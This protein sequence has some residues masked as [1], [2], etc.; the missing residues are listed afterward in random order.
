MLNSQLHAPTALPPIEP[1]FAATKKEPM[2]V[3]G[4]VEPLAK[5]EIL[6]FL[7]EVEPQIQPKVKSLY[8]QNYPGSF[9]ISAAVN[10][11]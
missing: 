6:L 4:S 8:R 1:F 7:L 3:P 10:V 2:W 11:D 9:R 5:E